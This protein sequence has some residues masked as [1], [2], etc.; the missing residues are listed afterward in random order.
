[1]HQLGSSP[2]SRV[3]QTERAGRPVV[4]K[5]LVDSPGAAERFAR[6]VAALRIAARAT[7]SVAPALLDTDP[8]SLTLVLEYLENRPPAGD[9]IVDYAATLARLHATGRPEDAAALPRWAGPTAV[10][11]DAFVSLAEALGVSVTTQVRGEL[12]DLV[13][14]L[15]ALRGHALLHGDPCPSN[16]LHTGDGVR[17]VDFENASIGN[18]VVELAYLRIGFPTCWCVT[19]A[20][21]RLLARAEA[22]YGAT[23]DAD[24]TDA[25]AG[26]L[27]RGDALVERAERETVDHL[28]RLLDEDW[29]WGTATGRERLLHRL[30]VVAGLTTDRGDLRGL[31]RLCLEL[32]RRMLDRW[33][34]LVPPP[35]RRP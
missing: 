25:C 19:T 31:G 1:M 15:G 4:V 20:S 8:G 34:W 23:F 9:W 10:D 32:R 7:P 28:A 29:A 3:W 22:A 14:R 5:Q 24:L 33:P 18:G 30:G 13:R 35:S 11:V 21:P 16:D 6:E 17:F 27:I 12:G 2:R 26:W